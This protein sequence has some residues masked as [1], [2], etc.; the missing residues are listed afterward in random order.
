M[1]GVVT[2]QE[3]NRSKVFHGPPSVPKDV[4]KAFKNNHSPK[5]ISEKLCQIVMNT[6]TDYQFNHQNAWSRRELKELVSRFNFIVLAQDTE[7]V[8]KNC[9][10]LPKIREMLSISMYL[11]AKKPE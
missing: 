5:Q 10:N 9:W 11:L 3:K 2:I 8:L 7:V 1:P 6:E 4:Y